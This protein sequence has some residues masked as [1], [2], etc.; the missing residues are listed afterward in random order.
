ML[1]VHD[2]IQN[3]KYLYKRY[4]DWRLWQDAKQVMSLQSSWVIVAIVLHSRH[5]CSWTYQ[6]T[7]THR[8]TGTGV[9]FAAVF[10]SFVN[11]FQEWQKLFG[12]GIA[13]EGQYDKQAKTELTWDIHVGL[14]ESKMWD[15]Q[16]CKPWFNSYSI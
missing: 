10:L 5:L 9:V 1:P 16:L 12:Q 3:I 2:Q 6:Q 13:I 7:D 14:W 8:A 11:N 4:G 15:K